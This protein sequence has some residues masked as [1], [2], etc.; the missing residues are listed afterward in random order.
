MEKVFFQAL[1]LA[2]Q[3][4][5]GLMDKADGDVGDNGRRASFHKLPEVFECLV[6]F[7]GKAA[8]V[9]SFPRIFGPNW[10]VARPEEVE[11]VV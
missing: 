9:A 1:E 4:V 7:A 6:G 5:I 2:V 11:I 8:N 3:Q 10:K